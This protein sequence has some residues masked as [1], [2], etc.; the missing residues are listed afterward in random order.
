MRVTPAVPHRL[1]WRFVPVAALCLAACGRQ[2]GPIVIG[3]AGP[4]EDPLGV[5]ELRAARLAVDQINQHGGLRGGRLLRLRVM[6]DSGTESGALRVAQALVDDPAVAAVVG[7]VTSGTTIAASRIYGGGDD[8]VP[9]ISPSASSPELSGISPFVFR[10]CPSDLFHGPALARFAYETLHARRAGVLYLNDD[11]GRGVRQAFAAEFARLGGVVV[12]QDPFLPLTPSLEPYVSRMRG[13]GVDVVMLATDVPGAELALRELRRQGLR[14]PVIGSDAL[15]GIEVD[16]TLAEGIHVSSAY[17]PDRAG[18]KN[19]AFVVEY[20]RATQ[21]QRPNDM[22]GLTYDIVQLLAGALDA[23]GPDRQGLRDYL[24]GIGTRRQA[25]EGVTGRVA[26][27]ANGDV[28]GKQLTIAV[29][30]KGRL[31]AE[32]SE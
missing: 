20:F 1:S 8:P 27:D 4:M 18:D 5:A 9:V 22:A 13:A 6:D 14:W 26:F 23:V 25:F 24:A 29:V 17:L 10:V 15:V 32:A 31:V 3:L 7:H 19:A 28:P 30:R 2:T 12:E 21:G 11:Y 16:T